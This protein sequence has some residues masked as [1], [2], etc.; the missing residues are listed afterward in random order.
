MSRFARYL[1]SCP[2]WH[3]IDVDHPGL[4]ILHERPF[5]FAVRGALRLSAAALFR[6]DACARGAPAVGVLASACPGGVRRRR[7]ETNP[8]SGRRTFSLDSPVLGSLSLSLP[9]ARLSPTALSL[10]RGS[11]PCK[12]LFLVSL[13]ALRPSL[14]SGCP[15]PV[16]LRL[17]ASPSAALRR[18]LCRAGFLRPAECALLRAKAAERLTPQT[19]DNDGMAGAR[20]SMGCVARNEEARAGASERASEGAR[21]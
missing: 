19:F 16:L 18:S 11:L 13:A 14:P 15:P 20:S 21:E 9:R 7:L 10:A 6:S 12:A 4:E 8:S 1:R 5:I 2:P 17:S 3:R